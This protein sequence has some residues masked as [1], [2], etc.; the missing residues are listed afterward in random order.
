MS[1]DTTPKDGLLDTVAGLP[2]LPSVGDVVDEVVDRLPTL[3]QVNDALPDV[4]DLEQ[5]GE[6]VRATGDHVVVTT[7][8]RL[9]FALDGIL[10]M[11][12]AWVALRLAWGVPGST[13]DE[14]GALGLFA[15][16]PAGVA[17][18]VVAAVGF[19]LV[20]LREVIR[21]LTGKHCPDSVTRLGVGGEG[22]AYAGLAWSAAGFAIGAGRR[23][24][25][26]YRSLTAS[27]LGMP[28][29]RWL[30]AVLGVAVVGVG[31]FLGWMGVASRFTDELARR[32]GSVV[33]R[34]GQVG[35]VA[36]GVGFVV[37]GGLFVAAAWHARSSEA[38]GLDGAV[39]TL[40]AQPSGRVLLTVLA[41]GFLCFGVTLL[42]QARDQKV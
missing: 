23:D 7:G 14:S 30:V 37:M 16:S 40:L 1:D 42:V 13:V 36:K 18:L 4:V 20:A 35:Y 41:A 22:L 31:L 17:V 34:V 28:A 15:G 21:G 10:H 3:E 25:D 26:S 5:V 29:G 27:L 39:R 11:L 33:R 32:L 38:T 24:T 6:V 2:S 19:G 8:A 12:I 9:G